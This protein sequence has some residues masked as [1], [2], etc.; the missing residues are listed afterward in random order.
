MV[1]VAVVG[2]SNTLPGSPVQ[3][4]DRP[5]VLSVPGPTAI[6]IG[7][8]RPGAQGSRPGCDSKRSQSVVTQRC[9][10]PR[11][12]RSMSIACIADVAA[13]NAVDG[14]GREIPAL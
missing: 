5:A 13:G 12:R 9:H 6:Q 7:N 14:P 1:V 4:V 2:D 11:D 3:R 10:A 8:E